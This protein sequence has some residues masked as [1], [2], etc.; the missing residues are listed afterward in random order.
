[1]GNMSKKRN[2]LILCLLAFVL[3]HPNSA[4]G[5]DSTVY[6]S[7][8]R[9]II[10][11]G[12]LNVLF[13]NPPDGTPVQ[14][15]KTLHAPI[16]Q[17]IGGVLFIL[18]AAA[19]AEASRNLSLRIP[20]MPASLYGLSSHEAIWWGF[21]AYLLALMTVYLLYEVTRRDYDT[22]AAVTASVAMLYG[23]PLLI[24][25]AVFPCQTNLPAAFLAS[26]LLYVFHFADRSLKRSWLLMGAI[27]SLGTFIRHEFAV[28]GILLLH[29]LFEERQQIPG[30]RWLVVLA[31]L[32]CGS[33]L[34]ILPVL[35]VREVLFGSQ[36]SSYGPQLDIAIFLKS[37]LML[38][39]PRNSLF[40][41]WP[42]MALALG[43]YLVA[44]R[45]NPMVNHILC[46]IL[47]LGTLLCGSTL[48]WSGDYGDS[49]GQRRF[50]FLYPCFVLFLARLVDVTKKY[51]V[52]VAGVCAVCTCWALLMFA[53]YGV[54]WN[55]PD[56][57]TGYLMPNDHIR[58][59]ELVKNHAA[60]FS[61][62]A[63]VLIFL[64]K[65]S[66]AV[67][68]LPACFLLLLGLLYLVRSF[69][70]QQLL[71]GTL[72]LIATTAL[73]TILFLV[74]AEARGRLVFERFTR[75]NPH[76]VT[77][78]RN[79]EMNYEMIGSMADRLSF[80]LELGDR[81]GAT[82]FGEQG[83][84]FLLAEAPDQVARFERIQKALELRHS[85]GWY[86]LM[87][88]QNLDDLEQWYEAALVSI[89]NNQA[90]GDLRAL[91]RY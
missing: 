25:V 24:Y 87:P 49:F 57:S 59:V 79:Y 73:I 20:H 39:G 36:G 77:V 27:W 9:S 43:G 34:F 80:F 37:P 54:R 29:A 2:I 15:T 17:N 35:Q 90:P 41:F 16:H 22:S 6:L 74:Q 10:T 71:D 46:I 53:A 56:G 62:K 32:V 72:C 65:H 33:M 7:V 86:R 47:I 68:L 26:L 52:A 42:V 81:E 84:R 82:G 60:E 85:L 5:P 31:L 64:P 63:G 83:R 70:R 45:K 21:M 89:R 13:Q 58:I 12:S 19:L 91:Y 61:A 3:Y 44:W 88:E 40:V 69:T 51:F 30:R 76:L 38:F 4:N 11:T 67:L 18:P 8:A 55:L 66:Y 50:M 75:D 78:T 28:W 14:V 1:M 48:F 23:G